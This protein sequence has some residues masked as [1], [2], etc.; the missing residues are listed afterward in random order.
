[1]IVRCRPFSEREAAAGYK[2]VLQIDTT[3]ATVELLP[4]ATP[5]ETYLHPLFDESYLVFAF[6]AKP[7]KAEAIDK[8]P[9]LFTYDGSFD[10]QTS[11][12]TVYAA[13]ASRIVESVLYGFNGTILAYGILHFS[14]FLSGIRAECAL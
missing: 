3:R 1:M 13:T 8:T 10:E 7:E 5:S 14:S 11:Q 2:K 12:E 6:V 9:R 4:N